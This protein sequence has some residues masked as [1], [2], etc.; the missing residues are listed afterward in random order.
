ML[1]T[2]KHLAPYIRCGIAAPE[3]HPNPLDESGALRDMVV[4]VVACMIVP[5]AVCVAAPFAGNGVTTMIA[6]L[7]CL[8]MHCSSEVL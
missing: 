7:L 4:I 1:C 6:H 8:W 5:L 2:V 3:F